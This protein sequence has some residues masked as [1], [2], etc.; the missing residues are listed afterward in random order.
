MN[1]NAARNI[2]M[3]TLWMEKGKTSKNIIKEASK[4]YGIPESDGE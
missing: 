1:F 3:S 4:Y 2:V